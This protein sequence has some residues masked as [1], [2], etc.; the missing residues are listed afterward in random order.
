MPANYQI[1]PLTR[2]FLLI[3]GADVIACSHHRDLARAVAREFRNL[4]GESSAEGTVLGGSRPQPTPPAS[5]ARLSEMAHTPPAAYAPP[6][7]HKVTPPKTAE[8][9][10]TQIGPDLMVEYANLTKL[11]AEFTHPD[12]DLDYETFLESVQ[13]YCPSVSGEEVNKAVLAA[14]G[15]SMNQEQ[16][17]A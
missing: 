10:V 14:Q 12:S 5:L 7:E 6:Q 3:L 15:L 4:R 16:E 11:A 1:V 2:G 8:V 9:V 17:N 13:R